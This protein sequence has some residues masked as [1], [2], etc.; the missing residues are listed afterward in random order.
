MAKNKV[1]FRAQFHHLLPFYLYI[2]V[3]IIL[4]YTVVGIP[5]LPFWLLGLGLY[6]CRRYYRRLECVLTERTLEIKKGY[7]IRLE[8]TILLEK[9]QDMTLKH[10]PLLRA[11]GLTQLEI[12]TAGQ[13]KAE[14]GSEGKLV[15]IVDAAGLRD[16][17]LA[18]RDALVEQTAADRPAGSPAELL[19]EIRNILTGMRDDLRRALEARSGTSLP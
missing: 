16:R 7:L 10:G 19:R 5:L 13:S 3:A 18:Q 8:K 9:I 1:V 4:L 17:V 6:A 11:F 15:G 2:N 12:E 14:G